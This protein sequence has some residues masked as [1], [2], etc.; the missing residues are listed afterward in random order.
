[1]WLCQGEAGEI[2]CPGGAGLVKTRSAESSC[3]QPCSRM[4]CP[5]LDGDEGGGSRRWAGCWDRWRSSRDASSRLLPPS[6]RRA[7]GSR[8]A[9]RRR[10]GRRKSGISPSSMGAQVA[11]QLLERRVVGLQQTGELV[12]QLGEM[13]R[14][15]D[16]FSQLRMSCSA[17]SR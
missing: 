16:W 12:E 2:P 13:G 9:P 3:S 15:L 4:R 1:M 10:A 14:V 6:S 5:V 7:P 11:Q 8:C 17:I